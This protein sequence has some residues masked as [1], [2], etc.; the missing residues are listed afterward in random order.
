MFAIGLMVVLSFNASQAFAQNKAK[1]VKQGS[2]YIGNVKSPQQIAVYGTP[3]WLF[4]TMSVSFVNKSCALT[5]NHCVYSI[6]MY[7]GG[8]GEALQSETTKPIQAD[9]AVKDGKVY[10]WDPDAEKPTE[11][12]DYTLIFEI[13]DNA[14]E[15]V[16]TN[17]K[18]I[19][20]GTYVYMGDYNKMKKMSEAQL[21]KLEVEA[22]MK[23]QRLR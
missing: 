16:Q 15:L 8:L 21:Q 17:E 11:D 4:S 22:L 2:V 3:A 7:T 23:L 10:V 13:K 20:T 12:A 6:N 5:F 14:L 19:Q 1:T 9:Y 18:G